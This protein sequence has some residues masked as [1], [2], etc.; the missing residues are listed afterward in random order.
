MSLYLARAKKKSLRKE[1]LQNIFIF[2]LP[3]LFAITLTNYSSNKFK[4]IN[5]Q[6]RVSTLSK[7][8][9]DTSLSQR[10]R[11]YKSALTSISKYPIFG[12][13]IGNWEIE[14]VKYENP[15]LKDFVVPYH[16]HNDYLEVAAE[17]GI[18]GFFFFFGSI[19]YLF[20]LLI[21]N[22][23]FR[24]KNEN[25]IFLLYM[26]IALSAY[27]IDSMFNFPFDRTYQ[28]IYMFTILSVIINYL[29]I[30]QYDYNIKYFKPVFLI[31]IFLYPFSLYSSV[32]FFNASKQHALLLYYFNNNDF[33]KPTIEE[34]ETYEMDYPNITPTSLSLNTLKGF[35]YMK[36][37][38]PKEAINF[39]R[40]GIKNSPHI[41]LSE[42]GMGLL[43]H[44]LVDQTVLCFIQ[45][46]HLKLLLIITHSLLITLLVY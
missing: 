16:T 36:N 39:F 3:V 37:E 29:P 41:Y 21:K 31:L 1:L 14:S 17:S 34:I 23:F 33:S 44:H 28:Q 42:S 2:I 15:Y 38:K 27:L 40:K 7:L 12:I 30:K 10:L 24:D 32:K 6:D 46:R 13:G 26:L 5:F 25:T 8:N 22:I 4:T 11:Y 45:K 9:T 35:W 20:F 18:I 19:F 43:T